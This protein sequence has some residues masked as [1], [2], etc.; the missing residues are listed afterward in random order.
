MKLLSLEAR[1]CINV[2]NGETL[3]IHNIGDE[4]SLLPFISTLVK[5]HFI[6]MLKVQAVLLR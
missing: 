3:R 4:D 1:C 5:M 6:G 2:P